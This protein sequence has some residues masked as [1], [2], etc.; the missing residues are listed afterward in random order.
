MFKKRRI[1]I[2]LK[3]YEKIKKRKSHCITKKIKKEED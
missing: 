2:L 1:I 3:S